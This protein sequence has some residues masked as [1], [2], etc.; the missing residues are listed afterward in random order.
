MNH[1][2]ALKN[3]NSAPQAVMRY[4]MRRSRS[5]HAAQRC[6][7]ARV[8]TGGQGGD[9]P[10][11][12]GRARAA[13]DHQPG[14]RFEPTDDLR[15]LD[16][17]GCANGQRLAVPTNEQVSAH[18]SR[19]AHP[20]ATSLVSSRIVR[21]GGTIFDRVRVAGLAGSTASIEVEL[22]GPFPSR[23]AMTCTGSPYWRRRMNATAAETHYTAGAGTEGRPQRTG[24]ALSAR[25]SSRAHIRR[26]AIRPRRPS[27][28]P[29]SRPGEATRQR[30]L[31]RRLG[32]VGSLSCS[33][34]RR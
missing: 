14:A 31:A 5:Q 17:Q 28:R 3:S 18:V 6:R 30:M 11:A 21:A 19:L 25:R 2:R 33:E 4:P 34:L 13:P 20:V 23:S 16:R 27:A 32:A 26:V 8:R 12:D 10:Q 29:S 1:P 9:H 7:H 22:F 15:P 24:S